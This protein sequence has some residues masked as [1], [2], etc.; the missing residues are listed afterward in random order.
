MEAEKGQIISPTCTG[1]EVG[2]GF[3]SVSVMWNP[4]S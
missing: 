1:Q 4:G 3:E 2:L